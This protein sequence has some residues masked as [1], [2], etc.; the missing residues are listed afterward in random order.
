MQVKKAEYAI[1]NSKVKLIRQL[2]NL[3][4]EDFASA[5]GLTRGALSQIEIGKVTPTYAVLQAIV[6]KY[7]IDGN[8]LLNDAIE[9]EAFE[10]YLKNPGKK[11]TA[12]KATP[13]AYEVN[14]P[15]P[16]YGGLKPIPLIPIDALASPGRGEL[17][18]S[19]SQVENRYIVPEFAKADYLIRV[20]GSSMYPKYYPGDILACKRV[21]KGR[22]IQWNK[23]HVI[24]TA[25]GVMVK[26]IVKGEQTS[27]W[28]LKSDNKE[29]QDIDVEPDVDVYSIS[30]VLGVIRL[31]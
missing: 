1:I 10:A 4:Q 31:E 3:T 25:Q 13:T 24:D 26:R 19:E 20:K 21:D 15:L 8:L 9:L 30:L 2:K 12:S 28:T 6:S 27:H 11:E 14:E 17:T 5:V 7:N 22:F 29:Y 23:A 16:Q 18:I